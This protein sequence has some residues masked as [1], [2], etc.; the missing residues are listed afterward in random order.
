MSDELIA[1]IINLVLG[2]VLHVAQLFSNI[3]SS[4]CFG[5]K[6]EFDKAVKNANEIQKAE[7]IAEVSKLFCKHTVSPTKETSDTK[8]DEL[9]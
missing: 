6:V 1:I 8:V 4:S 7:I 9:K 2:A 5:G 3:R